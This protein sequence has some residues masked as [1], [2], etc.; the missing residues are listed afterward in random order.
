V[1]KNCHVSV[2]ACND[3]VVDPKQLIYYG[4]GGA[5]PREL[6]SSVAWSRE[7]ST[8]PFG[9]PSPENLAELL[10]LLK[11][12]CYFNSCLPLL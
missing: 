10:P 8:R 7:E 3:L 1:C 9:P 11:S 4:S 12:I 2:I 6:H 5:H